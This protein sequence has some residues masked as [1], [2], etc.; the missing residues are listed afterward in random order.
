[1]NLIENVRLTLLVS[2]A[3]LVVALLL[4]R[5]K[6]NVL[7][8][9]L[10]AP[11]HAELIGLQVAYHPMRLRVEV[12]VPLDQEL[13]SHL[14]DREHGPLYA[15]PS[16][17]FAPGEHTFELPLPVLE[18]GEHFFQLSTATQRTVRVFRLQ[19]R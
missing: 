14:V 3:L 10:P 9:D 2:L 5:F 17:N 4:R 11:L 1:M 18:D 8:K 16:R 7:A 15:W 19:Q 6:R 12:F 13:H